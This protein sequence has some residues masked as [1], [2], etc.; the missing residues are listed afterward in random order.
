MSHKLHTP[1][2]RN[3]T[4]AALSGQEDE[5]VALDT[6]LL[7]LET[8][9]SRCG[10]SALRAWGHPVI[11]GYIDGGEGRHGVRGMVETSDPVFLKM[12]LE[13]RTG[14]GTPITFLFDPDAFIRKWTEENLP[15]IARILTHRKQHR[16]LRHDRLGMRE[17]RHDLARGGELG[18]SKMPKLLRHNEEGPT[19]LKGIQSV[20]DAL[21]EWDCGRTQVD[22]SIP[23][24]LTLEEIAA[25]K[26][27]D[28]DGFGRVEGDRDGGTR[29]LVRLKEI[30]ARKM[31][32]GLL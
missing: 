3:N 8:S 11:F 25:N 10:V 26:E 32:A 5:I 1:L 2:R 22:G 16:L 30:W 18:D 4:L 31:E 24:F 20:E 28:P 27:W 13:A 9:Q 7:G 14:E 23:S 6:M 29:G 12:G 21:D 15:L 19:V 17:I